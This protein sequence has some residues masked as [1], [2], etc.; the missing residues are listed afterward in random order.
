MMS[1]KSTNEGLDRGDSI[2]L[3]LKRIQAGSERFN[4]SKFRHV[5]KNIN[6][7]I[8]KSSIDSELDFI[9]FLVYNELWSNLAEFLYPSCNSGVLINDA[10]HFTI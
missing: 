10:E 3:C 7:D 2:T 1:T 9:D 4:K 5:R 6:C 8:N